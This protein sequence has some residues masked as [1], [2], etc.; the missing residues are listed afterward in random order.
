M[1][2]NNQNQKTLLP[3]QIIE[4]QF[5]KNLS[6]NL[7]LTE[8]QLKKGN[9]AFLKLASDPKL[10][11]ANNISMLSAAYRVSLLDYK[12]DNA[13]AFIKYGNEVQIQLQYQGYLEDLFA[14]GE[15]EKEDVCVVPIYEGIDYKPYIDNNG[16]RILTIPKINLD[17]PF[18][19]L[20]V[21]GYYAQA[22]TKS[23]RYFTCLMSVLALKS[24]SERYSISQRAFKSGK[25]TSSIWNSDFDAMAKKTVLKAL[26]REVLKYYP[27]D[28]LEKSVQ[29]DQV[30]VH[31]DGEVSYKDSPQVEEVDFTNG[32]V[33]SNVNTQLFSE[34]EKEGE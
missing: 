24:W 18:K 4:H 7:H 26:C 34:E 8:T 21:L 29:L 13:V 20:K 5:A 28:R 25:A 32:E 31:D 15:F 9:T 3:E 12:S 16:Q 11:G 14:T 27:N 10:Q 30:V 17:D 19:E 33:K 6:A 2:T 22:K 23:G 1:A